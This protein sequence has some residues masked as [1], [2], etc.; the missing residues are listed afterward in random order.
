MKYKIAVCDDSQPDAA[1]ITAFV[2]E[3]ARISGNTAVTK[4]FQSAEEFL[5][6]YEDD[7]EYDILLLDIEMKRMNGVELAK[8]VR[9]KNREVQIVFITGYNDYIADGYDVEALHYILKPVHKEKFFAIL[10]RACEKLKKNEVAL[11]LEMSDGMEK[12]PLYEIR[13]I[14]V[15]SNYVTIHGRQDYT[16]KMTLSGLEKE[17]DDSFFRVGRSYIVNMK[18]IRK[19][20][21]K[22]VLLEGGTAVPMSRGYYEPLNQ[23]FIHY[24]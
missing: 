12:I 17:L 14:E 23:A 2:K 5:F 7:K 10:N 15:R 20:T 6:H 24:F 11:L 16:V 22:D 21:K 8:K 3:W 19:I 9:S 13:Y 1:Y 4:T 18:Y